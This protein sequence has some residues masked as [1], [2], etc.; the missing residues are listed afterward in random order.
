MNALL[1]CQHNKNVKQIIFQ[2]LFMVSL[3]TVLWAPGFIV[4]QFTSKMDS[5]FWHY[6]MWH[7]L[8]LT[9]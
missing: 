2:K 4:R 7:V 6:K 9:W 3:L 8:E 5:Y 1:A